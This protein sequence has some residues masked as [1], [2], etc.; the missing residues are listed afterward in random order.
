MRTHQSAHISSYLYQDEEKLPLAV[1][2]IV[3]YGAHEEPCCV[4]LCVTCFV[5]C[6]HTTH[7]C[8]DKH[9]RVGVEILTGLTG[10]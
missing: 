10:F 8:W 2:H 6:S 7:T 1:A 5:L 3:I 4:S 9:V